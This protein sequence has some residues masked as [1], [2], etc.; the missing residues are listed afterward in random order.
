MQHR[1]CYRTRRQLAR[2]CR[3]VSGN[4]R[5]AE[6]YTRIRAV[7]GQVDIARQAI[8]LYPRNGGVASSS[9]NGC[10]LGIADALCLGIPRNHDVTGTRLVE[11]QHGV[12]QRKRHSGCCRTVVGIK[13]VFDISI[14][15]LIVVIELDAELQRLATPLVGHL[16]TNL[17]RMVVV[18]VG[19]PLQH[20]A[21]LTVVTG[22]AHGT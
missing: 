14:A 21:P 20:P 19:I 15:K 8:H 9:V 10:Q 2:N 13:A 1:Y 22:E 7:H 4:N 11:G 17:R 5:T 12:I 3:T 16:P 6:R 18:I